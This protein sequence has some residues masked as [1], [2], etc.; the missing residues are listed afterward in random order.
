M[1]ERKD[2]LATKPETIPEK[3]SI[4]TFN[5][6]CLP[7][8]GAINAKFLRLN[9]TRTNLIIE[10]IIQWNHNSGPD[11]APDI[12]CFQ[13]AMALETRSLLDTKLS[14]LYPHNT[15]NFGTETLRG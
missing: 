14:F 9:K 13:E 1:L 10:R 3:I 2:S 8:L 5:I 15:K 4:M 6:A 11:S 12:L 7:F